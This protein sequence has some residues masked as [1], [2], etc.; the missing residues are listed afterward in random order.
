MDALWKTKIDQR[1][2]KA[3]VSH[4]LLGDERLA[5]TRLQRDRG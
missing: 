5:Q 1:S 3:Q 4:I 2:N